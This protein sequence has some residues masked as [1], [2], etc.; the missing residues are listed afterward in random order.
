M[1]KI[2]KRLVDS[3]KPK[4]ARFFIWDSDLK[5][6][7]LLVLPTGV[8]SYV[9][10]YR[11]AE[12]RTRRLT[13]GKHGTFTP[14]TA[15]T[16][17]RK[18][19]RDVEDGKDPQA[20]K[21]DRRTALTVA[22]LLDKY[23]QSAKFAE[24]ADST[25][26]I[27]SGR[28][29]RHLKPIFGRLVADKVKRED[30]RKGFAAIRDGKTAKTIK[31]GPRGLARVTGGEGTARKAIRLLSAAYSWA[32]ED[33]LLEMNPT[34]GVDVGRDDERDA[35]I[36]SMNQY[37]AIFQTIERMENTLQIRRPVADA[38][39]LITL[40]GARRGEIAGL[41]WRHVD[42][43]TGNIVIPKE[44]HKTRKTHKPRIIGLDPMAQAII[45]RQPEGGPDDFVFKPA[46][47]K[48]PINLNK[49]WRKVR[50]E[51]GLTNDIV[52]HSFRHS[53]ATSMAMSNYQAAQI[54]AVLGHR[55]IRTSQKY[56]HIVEQQR[57]RLA[58][59]AAAGISAAMSGNK[60]ADV[61]SLKRGK[62]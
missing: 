55:D 60:S 28:V 34:H 6:F 29:E 14:D 32:I 20:E 61:V 1:P 37:E 49:P 59:R 45:A 40:T 5:G 44:E 35:I 46:Y 41:R 24:K 17:A 56:I 42:L 52:L 21:R 8:M 38:I 9:F 36:E 16:K 58:E 39:R 19:Q 7:G 2:T 23:L 4:K 53:L 43:K 31:T 25:R 15:R 3:Q 12:G 50:N 62:Q 22:D 13:I 30:V 18:Y 11:T 27:D 47:G 26:E 48:G 51:A 10:Q 57:A 54:S 33:S